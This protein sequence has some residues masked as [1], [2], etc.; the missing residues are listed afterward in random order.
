MLE[1]ISIL[2]SIAVLVLTPIQT[3]QVCAGKIN[4]KYKGTPQAYVAAVRKQIGLMIWVG[5][6]FGVLD[7]VLMF[8]AS[9]PG[10]WIVKLVAAALWIGVSGVSF[11]SS[12]KL[13][14][15]PASPEGGA[16]I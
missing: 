10:E 9:E 5:A 6:V 13:A 1:L 3:A 12:Q 2:A 7:L 4:P 11:Y 8:L 15:L 14:G 16:T